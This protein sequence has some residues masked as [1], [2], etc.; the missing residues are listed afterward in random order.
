[1]WF[2][3]EDP[4]DPLVREAAVSTPPALTAAGD[5]QWFVYGG[6][7]E[8][9]ER[10]RLFPLCR[11]FGWVMDPQPRASGS[12]AGRPMHSAKRVARAA[13][14][15]LTRSALTGLR[16]HRDQT[17]VRDGTLVSTRCGTEPE[18]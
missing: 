2:E 4:H 7:L 16:E 3:S 5:G 18:T 6:H 14:G 17:G 13:H 11:V 8:Q 9:P 1:M 12:S 15:V 10:E